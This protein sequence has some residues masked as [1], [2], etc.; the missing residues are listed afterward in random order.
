MKVFLVISLLATLCYSKDL[1]NTSVIDSSDVLPK[2]VFIY[3]DIH[4]RF[5]FKNYYDQNSQKVSL[6]S[7]FKDE[8][9]FQDILEDEDEN[10]RSITEGALK[11]YGIDDFSS[12]AGVHNAQFNIKTKVDNL[13]FGYGISKNLSIFALLPRVSITTSFKNKFQSSS[14]LDN[15]LKKLRMDGNY[16]QAN[17]IEN[18]TNNPIAYKLEEYN[19]NP[20]YLS[21][22]TNWGDL[23]LFSRYNVYDSDLLKSTLGLLVAF[24]TGSTDH[25]NDFMKVYIGDS[26]YD[27]GVEVLQEFK[28]SKKLKSLITLQ[29]TNQLPFTS[30]YRIPLNSRNPLSPDIDQ[31]TKIN[32]GD[33]LKSTLQSNYTFNKLLSLGGGY[34]LQFKSPDRYSGT[35]F[36]NNRYN[37]LEKN[38]DQ[39]MHSYFLGL[40]VN[41]LDAFIN[42]K[43][44]LPINLTTTYTHQF[45]GKNVPI[46]HE[47]QVSLLSFY[48]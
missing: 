27:I 34:Q 29:Y 9:S 14:K 7:L 44:I 16:T 36:S 22:K 39:S 42:K 25:I 33:Q 30:A 11:A 48:K 43:F 20:Q 47:V 21:E 40:T 28:I 38:T 26:Q 41:T 1:I 31:S 10:F 35:K 13:F 19:Y 17:T 32:F 2:S 37:F 18:I 12:L 5:S 46:A 23:R 8:L 4:S 3:G 15:L 45:A 6:G 24:P